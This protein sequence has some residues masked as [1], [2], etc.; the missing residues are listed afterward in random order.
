M[1]NPFLKAYEKPVDLDDYKR[2][3]NLFYNPV[4][5]C[6]GCPT[7]DIDERSYTD[8]T[9]KM[10]CK[11]CDWEVSISIP[12]IVDLYVE[13]SDVTI[14]RVNA[15]YQMLSAT[16]KDQ[17]QFGKEVFNSAESILKDIDAVLDKQEAEGQKLRADLYDK[18]NQLLDIYYK[19]QEIYPK[20]E[21]EI[22]NSVVKDLYIVVKNEGYPLGGSR[23]KGVATQYSLSEDFISPWLEW[24][25]FVAEYEELQKEVRD[26]TEK[27]YKFE[28]KINVFNRSVM[29]EGPKV[30]GDTLVAKTKAKRI[31]I[32]RTKIKPKKGGNVVVTKLAS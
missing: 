9:L 22:K 11:K 27:L 19:R 14:E 17:F 28:D 1:S 2:A 15:I 29:I 24:L 18:Y 25:H 7:E 23:L 10:A 32:K 5:K 21:K 4:A 16:D 30:T 26:K 3:L 31:K 12:K 20:L 6:P 8:N 13:Q